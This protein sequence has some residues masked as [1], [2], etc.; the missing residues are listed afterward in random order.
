MQTQPEF[1][2]LRR[3]LEQTIVGQRDLLDRL[4]IALLTGGHI[5]L[6]SAPGLAKTTA[7]KA[8]ASG[9]HASFQRIQFTPDLMPADITG[10]DVF[11]PKRGDFRFVEGPL[12]KEI[13]LADEIN[14]APPKVQSALLEAM[15]EHQITISGQSHAL[16]DLFIVMATQNPLEQAGTYPLP[17]A[18]LDRFM[19][20]VIIDYPDEAEE[21]EILERDRKLHFGEDKPALDTRLSP[22]TVLTA[23]REVAE[24][25]IED[26]LKRYVVSIVNATRQPEKWIPD[27]GDHIE[28]GAS[29]RATLAM[30]RAASAHAYVQGREYVIPDDVTDVASDVLRHRIIPSFTARASQVSNDQLIQGILDAIPVP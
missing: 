21:L 26:A 7:V 9:V 18:Q 30:V 20:H 22:E 3:H 12:F 5:L 15:E 4:L 24:I 23:R 6:E 17:E 13:I 29:P 2:T 28:F 1:L 19:F 11:D 10:S 8:L 25:H 27:W 14:R 16:P